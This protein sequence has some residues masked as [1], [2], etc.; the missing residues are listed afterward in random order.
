MTK[1]D[2]KDTIL[3]NITKMLTERKFLDR[4]KMR[5]NYEKLLKQKSEELIFKIKSDFDER[6]YYIMFTFGKLTTIKKV[7]GI[8]TFMDMSK[9]NNRLFIANKINQ[10]TYKQFLEYNNTEVF[11]EHELLVNIIDHDLQP[12]FEVLSKE[13]KK[14][15]FK[16]YKTK[17]MEMPK[18]LSI[19]PIARYYNLQNGDIVRIIRPSITSGYI[20]SYRLVSAVSV[21][22]LFAH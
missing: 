6:M 19:D 12:K 14:H 22:L 8:D 21:S 13:E 10:K 15:Y 17:K 3:L 2:T 16:S 18:M 4:S 20:V 11:F 7:Q 1:D 5:E 9:N